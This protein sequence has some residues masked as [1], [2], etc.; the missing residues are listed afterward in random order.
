M[1]AS[2]EY[3]RIAQKNGLN[4]KTDSVKIDVAKDCDCSSGT[5]KPGAKC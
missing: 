2:G 3:E 5:A 4:P 1:Q